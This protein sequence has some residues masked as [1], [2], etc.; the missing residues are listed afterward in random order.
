MERKVISKELIS[1][2]FAEDEIKAAELLRDALMDVKEK[3]GDITDPSIKSYNTITENKFMLDISLT[4][5][6]NYATK[7]GYGVFNVV[8]DGC[9]V[10][11][12]SIDDY[13]EVKKLLSENDENKG[14]T[15]MECKKSTQEILAMSFVTK[16]FKQQKMMSIRCSTSEQDRLDELC[17]AYPMFTKQ[18]LLSLIISFGMDAIG[19]HSKIKE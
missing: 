14:D 7:Y 6:K 10:K 17:E 1:N 2:L 5:I 11:Q 18:Y 12:L 13:R 9:V 8:G 4:T 3:S 15:A 16:D 19:F